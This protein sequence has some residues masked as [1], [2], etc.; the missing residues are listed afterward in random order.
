M[1]EFLVE[2]RE[3]ASAKSIEQSL[4]SPKKIPKDSKD[5]KPNPKVAGAPAVKAVPPKASPPGGDKEP[6]ALV[7]DPKSIPKGKGEKGK[8]KGIRARHLSLQKRK[9]KPLV[10]SSKCL[11]LACM[12]T[13]VNTLMP[14]LVFPRV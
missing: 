2:E 3:D 4:R 8:G 1:Q 13:I 11:V 12:G 9:Q 14:R 10:S 7:A 5:S 6:P